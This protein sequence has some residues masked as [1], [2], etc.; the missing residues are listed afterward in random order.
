MSALQTKNI[1][2]TYNFQGYG[3]LYYKNNISACFVTSSPNLAYKMNVKE[4][5]TCAPDKLADPV[6]D[7]ECIFPF[8]IVQGNS[9]K[10]LDAL[11]DGYVPMR[12]L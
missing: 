12:E 4:F 9:L 1:V 8:R 3:N 6:K 2:E 10:D 7:R 11:L 5:L